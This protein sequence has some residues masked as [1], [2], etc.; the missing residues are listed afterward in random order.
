MPGEQGT[1]GVIRYETVIATLVGVCALAVS[2]YTAYVQ[3][4]QVRAAVWPILEYDTSNQPTV[5]LTLANKGVG[6]AIVRH[7]RLTVDGA[8]VTNWHEAFQ[9]MLGPEPHGYSVSTMTGHVLS[10]G[11]SMDILIPYNAESA[12]VSFDRSNPTWIE[13]NKIRS[14][15]AVEICYSS[16]LGESWTLRSDY[17]ASSTVE[18]RACPTPSA[19]SF[20]E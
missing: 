1:R 12:P 8:P 15:V 19:A 4:Q 14:R 7:V 18:T 16:T 13:M 5:H 11:E 2:G 20:Q 3:R 9:K 10:P 6:P 17:N